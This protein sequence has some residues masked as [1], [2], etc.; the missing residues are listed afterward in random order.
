VLCATTATQK[1]APRSRASSLQTLHELQHCLITPL[2]AP[3]TFFPNSYIPWACCPRKTNIYPVPSHA[4]AIAWLLLNGIWQA[5]AALGSTRGRL[6][7]RDLPSLKRS[8]RLQMARQKEEKENLIRRTR[9]RANPTRLAPAAS[10]DLTTSLHDRTLPYLDSVLV[11]QRHNL[12]QEHLVI[13]SCSLR[14]HM[15]MPDPPL[16]D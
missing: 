16:L 3:P 12:R 15:P 2:L 4:Y 5:L 6:P 1:D 9:S 10:V 13:V 8:W 11:P 7:L 14:V